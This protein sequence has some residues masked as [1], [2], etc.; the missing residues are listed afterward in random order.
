MKIEK[1]VPMP[2]VNAG[3][4]RKYPLGDMEVGDSLL[5]VD[6]TDTTSSKLRNAAKIY[7]RR[8]G[9]RFT[10]RKVDEGV[11]VWRVE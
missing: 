11:R 1:N 7:G 10:S 4:F 8:N 5:D 9:M 3:G 6:A 2:S